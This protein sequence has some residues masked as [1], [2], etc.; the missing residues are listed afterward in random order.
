MKLRLLLVDDDV[1]RCGVI[2]ALMSD[3]YD[4]AMAHSVDQALSVLPHGPWGAALV[5][6]DLAEGGSGLEVLQAMREGSPRTF[7]IMYTSYY[8]SSLMRDIVRLAD[9][10]SVLDARE[11]SFLTCLRRTLDELF[12][13]PGESPDAADPLT[14]LTA[15]TALS[16][17]SL[18]FLAQLRAAAE[19]A[20]PVF[21]YGEPGAGQT[22]AAVML[23]EW[24]QAWRASGAGCRRSER[25]VATLRVPPL[26]E[27][28]QDLPALAQRCLAEYARDSGEP[29]KELA[30]DAIEDLLQREWFGNVVELRAVILRACQRAGTRQV[31]RA[32][33][34]PHDQQPPIRP[35]QHAKDEGQLDCM[36]RQLRTARN[37]TGA[38]KLEGCT[39]ANYIRMMRRLGILRAD[40]LGDLES[41]TRERARS[42]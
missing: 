41:Q 8:A 1:E 17:A 7:R 18:G 34:L 2:G 24:R 35:S 36:L 38:A 40:V 32:Q 26:R 30:P 13:P 11:V 19:T 37:V 16:P 10:H 39:R 22:R 4:C 3:G 28:R 25:P 14:P 9:P 5:D 33:D 29:L 21:L 15:W 6:Y 23:R 31:L 27:R 12:E 42:R 20:V